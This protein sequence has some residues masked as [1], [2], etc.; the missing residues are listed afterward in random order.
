M[1]EHI[2][3]GNVDPIYDIDNYVKE[4]KAKLQVIHNETV[5]LINK[6]KLRNKQNFDKK[7]NPIDLKVGDVVK[8]AKEPYEKFK[9]IY[10]GPYEVTKV[11]NANI[12][13]KLNNGKLYEV[14]KNRVVKY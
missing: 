3:S 5:E 7:I 12:Q 9:F 10:D 1:P 4:T 13:I 8:V 14:H 2:F 6:I 11:D